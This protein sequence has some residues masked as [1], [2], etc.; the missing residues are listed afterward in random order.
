MSTPRTDEFIDSCGDYEKWNSYR[1]RLHGFTRSLELE[2]IALK[3]EL[4]AA[5]EAVRLASVAMEHMGD[6]L[7]GMDAVD[8]EGIAITTPGFEAVDAILA[9]HKE[10]P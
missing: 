4:D 6:V 8:D 5:L 10:Q 2:T 9:K 7:N 3:E 1:D